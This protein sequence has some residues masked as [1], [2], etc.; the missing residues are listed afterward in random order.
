M[1]KKSGDW[2]E[3]IVRD[4]EIL[5]GVYKLDDE[6]SLSKEDEIVEKLKK[7]IKQFHASLNTK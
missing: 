1:L 3:L 2:N 4:I 7:N 6:E 5:G